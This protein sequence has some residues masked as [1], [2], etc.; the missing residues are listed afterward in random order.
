MGTRRSGSGRENGNRDLEQRGKTAVP[1]PGDPAG[2]AATAAVAAPS[3]PGSLRQVRGWLT[4][5]RWLW[6]CW[7]AWSD[8]PP[9]RELQ[10]LLEMV[11]T[12][13]PLTLYLRCCNYSGWS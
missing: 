10:A 6:R 8:L 13:R 4:P 1:E 9:P 3:W 2:E 12:G 7:Q 5:W 11:G